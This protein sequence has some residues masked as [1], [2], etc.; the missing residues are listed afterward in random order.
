MSVYVFLD[1]LFVVFHSFFIVFNLIGWIW[2]KTRKIHLLALGLT[3]ISWFILGIWYGL[4][5]CPCTDWHWQVKRKLGETELPF[6]YVKYYIDRLTG[7]E[8][9][10]LVLD[11]SVLGFG[12]A[13]FGISVW[14]NW[15][16]WRTADR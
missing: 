9:N 6:S 13:A 15:R 4:G 16:D 11:V 8:W 7:L 1:L 14:L 2:K 5:Y 3:M 10:A 12:L